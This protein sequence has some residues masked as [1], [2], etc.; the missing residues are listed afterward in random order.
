MLRNSLVVELKR[1]LHLFLSNQKAL[2]MRIPPSV[3]S[4][5]RHG[6]APFGLC[7]VARLLE[8]PTDF[9]HGPTQSGENDEGEER[10]LP[11]NVEETDRVDGD[12]VGFLMSISKLP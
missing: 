1:L 5:C 8:A 3:S 4:S 12:E 2:M 7:F 6:F 9:A 11:R 10:E